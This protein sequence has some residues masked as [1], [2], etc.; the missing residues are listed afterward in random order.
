MNK[1]IEALA[2]VICFMA[3]EFYQPV[4]MPEYIGK[5]QEE[6]K[7][8]MLEFDNTDLA[9]L[10]DALLKAEVSNSIPADLYK[11]HERLK[12]ELGDV[13][14]FLIRIA[15]FYNLTSKELL[16]HAATKMIKRVADSN[17]NKA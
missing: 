7:E 6:F 15:N 11:Q 8:L 17:Y 4:T 9:G 1:S 14:V 13:M 12:D 2:T 3:E 10:K 16:H 5:L